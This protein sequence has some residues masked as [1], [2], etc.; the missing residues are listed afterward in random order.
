MYF[1]KCDFCPYKTPLGDHLS[2][3]ITAVHEG[4]NSFKCAHCGYGAPERAQLEDHRAKYHIWNQ[5]ANKWTHK[6]HICPY[7]TTQWHHLRK[8]RSYRHTAIRDFVCEVCGHG[9]RDRH[10][11]EKHKEAVHEGIRDYKC[12]HCDYESYAK[13][14]LVNHVRK[15]HCDVMTTVKKRREE[16]KC[17]E[18]DYGSNKKHYLALHETESHPVHSGIKDYKCE[19]CDY[20]SYSKK[21]LVNH[22]R[23]NHCDITTVIKKRSEGLKCDE[24]G[25]SCNEEELLNLHMAESHPECAGIKDYKCD[26]CDYVSYAKK[27]LVGHVR[28]NH[29]AMTTRG[30][31]IIKKRSEQFKCDECDYSCNKEQFLNLHKAE[32]HQVSKELGD[33]DGNVEESIPILAKGVSF[34]KHTRT[35]IK[36]TRTSP[37]VTYSCGYCPFKNADRKGLLKHERQNHT[38]KD[39][40][41]D[42]CDHAFHSLETLEKHKAAMNHDRDSVTFFPRV[43]PQHSKGCQ[44][45]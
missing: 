31:F 42:K 39:F 3:H 24:C 22:V 7:T 19:H 21:Y 23:K 14:S 34:P 38:H 26:H 28:K 20:E 29:S 41:C 6:C 43:S 35:F 37:R 40:R 18:C 16:F 15:S 30:H 45:M 4:V 10:D 12:E 2:R 27:S 13:K 36:H 5:A 25:Y 11:L 44:D 17:D 9:A 1:H 8:H 32:S 33:K